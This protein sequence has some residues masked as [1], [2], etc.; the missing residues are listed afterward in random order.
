MSKALKVHPA[1]RVDLEDFVH[2]TQTFVQEEIGLS[3]LRQTLDNQCRVLDGFRIEIPDQAIYPGRVVVHNGYAIDSYGQRTFNDEY[4]TTSRTVTLEGANLA[5]WLEIEYVE[6]ESDSDAR[7]FWDP[8]VDQGTD[9]SGDAKPDGQEF[10]DTVSTRVALD[11]RICTPMRTGAA[12]FERDSDPTS[13][14]IPVARLTT[15][16][17]GKVAGLGSTTEK[18]ATVILE[19]LATTPGKLRVQNAQHF[20]VGDVLVGAGQVISAVGD[21]IAFAAGTCT[22]TDAAATFVASYIGQP[23]TISGATSAG[24]NGSFVVT[25]VPGPTQIQYGNAAGVTET[26]PGTWA[27]GIQETKTIS[28][29]DVASGII[30]LTGNIAN[31]HSPGNILRGTGAAAVNLMPEGRYGRYFQQSQADRR[32]LMFQA[33]EVHGAVLEQGT[34]SATDR[35]DQNLK[36]LKDYVDF[37]AAQ[38]EEMKWGHSNPLLSTV[39][40]QR[41]PPGLISALPT[42]PRYYDQAG[43]LQGTRT[44][45]ITVGDGA[46]SWGDFTGN[47]QAS[48]QA[49]IDNLPAGGGTIY[50]KAG[51]FALSFDVTINKNVELICDAATSFVC[52]G[53]WVIVNSTSSV[54]LRKLRL[55][56]GSSNN[57][58]KISGCGATPALF[59]M[60]ECILTNVQMS[61]EADQDPNSTFVQKCEFYGSHSSMATKPIVVTTATYKASG[62]WTNCVFYQTVATALVG[63]CW[64]AISSSQ[65]FHDCVFTTISATC[66][67]SVS[68]EALSTGVVFSNCKFGDSDL[69]SSVVCEVYGDSVIGIKFL[70]CENRNYGTLAHIKRSSWITVDDCTFASVQANFGLVIE[71]DSDIQI[72]NN[73]FIDVSGDGVSLSGCAAKFIATGGYQN[74]NFKIEGNTIKA[75]TDN[76]TGIVFWSDASSG[77]WPFRDITIKN[78]IFDKCEVPLY[79]E[80]TVGHRF[81]RVKIENNIFKDDLSDYQKIGIYGLADPDYWHWTVRNNTFT[82][83]NP[84][85][86]TAVVGGSPHRSAVSILGNKYFFRMEDNTATLIGRAGVNNSLMTA[87]GIPNI[88]TGWIRNNAVDG[89]YSSDGAAGDVVVFNLG[90]MTTVDVCGN[91]ITNAEGE[92]NATGFELGS[93]SDCTFENNGAVG[94]DAINALGLSNVFR[95]YDPVTG[96]VIRCLFDGNKSNVTSKNSFIYISVIRVES[97]KIKNSQV[98][99]TIKNGISVSI[100]TGGIA[101]DIDIEGNQI[102]EHTHNGISVVGI[103]STIINRIHV[104]NNEIVAAAASNR[105]IYVSNFN[106]GVIDENEV[107]Q[108]TVTEHGIF[109][110]AGTMFT[111]SHNVSDHVGGGA[112]SNIRIGAGSDM[113]SINDNVCKGTHAGAN[114]IQ[115]DSVTS[116]SGMMHDNLTDFGCNGTSHGDDLANNV[117]F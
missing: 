99:G 109:I 70:H 14:R 59:A 64:K 83:L 97:L 63:A 6:I 82:N 55:T 94:L 84:N 24:N 91:K 23:I 89:L 88:D 102:E 36:G 92:A 8:T 5:F 50:V 117:T 72:I 77:N 15:D 106:N 66:P 7:A 80:A 73:T 1:E 32:D 49:A 107:D 40:M 31:F 86:D 45:T 38:I 98:G 111:C 52:N 104:K 68:V 114:S 58:L 18:A 116:T 60:D 41:T 93:I 4:L 37:L 113:Y 2:A 74:S 19:V 22:L 62:F 101:K 3:N 20:L 76:V 90:N 28:T 56:R 65:L 85:N 25:G 100:A 105:N 108:K 39:S 48:I 9:P 71:N 54:V 34:R 47:T 30:T 61:I 33:D 51:T 87:F 43:G 26:F 12:G 57:G 11:W 79:F 35:S 67:A 27:V 110:E 13:A 75:S 10:G 29:T 17:A 44:A 21:S 81:H 115:S 96:S 53:G 78:N 95:C 42:Y 112:T 69:S 46:M 16:T 103:G